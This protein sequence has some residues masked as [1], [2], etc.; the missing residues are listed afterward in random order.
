MEKGYWIK[1]GKNGNC[2][3][4]E[5]DSLK[6]RFFKS[7]GGYNMV[8]VCVKNG[9][10]NTNIQ[11]SIAKDKNVHHAKIN[12]VSQLLSIFFRVLTRMSFVLK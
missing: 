6:K 4:E 12:M 5:I 9:C 1:S 10:V 7:L 11:G 2:P 3:E 8:D